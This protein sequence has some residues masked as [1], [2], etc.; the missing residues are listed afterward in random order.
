MNQLEKQIR[1][2][3]IN[4]QYER[5]KDAFDKDKV[6]IFDNIKQGDCFVFC[7][8]SDD[9]E[10]RKI[11]GQ[12][13]SGTYITVYSQDF[14]KE[15]I[16]KNNQELII[17]GDEPINLALIKNLPENSNDKFLESVPEV[18]ISAPIETINETEIETT[19]SKSKKKK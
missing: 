12:K 1:E 17:F 4:D 15:Q 7:S 2:L 3:K 6:L 8:N 18:V 10:R 11:E 9:R 13:V 5:L 19:E 16:A 14:L